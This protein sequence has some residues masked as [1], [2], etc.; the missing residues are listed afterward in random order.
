MYKGIGLAVAAGILSTLLSGAGYGTGSGNMVDG[1]IP[2]RDG[3]FHLAL[4]IAAFEDVPTFKARMDHIIR[5]YPGTRLAPGFK[6][7]FVRGEME[8]NLER[9]QREQGAPLNEATVQGVREVA[10]EL[11]VDASALQ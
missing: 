8:A 5:E 4:N 7:V 11:G 10:A 9:R 6:R 2:G 3:Q 1:P